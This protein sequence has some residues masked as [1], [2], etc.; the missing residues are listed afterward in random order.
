MAY[1][2]AKIRIKAGLGRFVSATL[3]G[4][5]LCGPS[6]CEFQVTF[7]SIYGA[8]TASKSNKHQ[9]HGNITISKSHEG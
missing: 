8:S 7:D 2:S 1:N 5:S 4:P 9:M 3:C 6:L